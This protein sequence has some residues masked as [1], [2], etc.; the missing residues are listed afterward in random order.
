[1]R[2]MREDELIA[3]AERDAEDDERELA[4][5]LTDLMICHSVN[6]LKAFIMKHLLEV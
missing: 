6:D 5:M 4:N 3:M 1:M 2:H